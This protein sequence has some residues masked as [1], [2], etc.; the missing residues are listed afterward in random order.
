[1]TDNGRRNN[2]TPNE[3]VA[4][5]ERDQDDGGDRDRKNSAKQS[6]C[7]QPEDPIQQAEREL[8]EAQGK[9][10]DAKDQAKRDEEIAKAI[11][12]YRGEQLLLEAEAGALQAQLAEGLE[13][14]NPTEAE[15]T[16]VGSVK[17]SATDAVETLETA[18][19]TQRQSLDTLRGA[20]ATTAT[21]LAEAKAEFDALKALG[22]NVQTKHRTADGLRKEAFDAIAQG[23]R[24]LAYYL[25]RHRLQTT[26][27]DEPVPIEVDDYSSQ[28]RDQAD[29]I[30]TLST[31]HRTDEATIK[32]QAKQLTDLEKALD[33]RRKSL[34]STI[35]G[36]LATRQ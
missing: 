3:D 2:P 26:I 6:P 33:D 15:K 14:L 8:Q 9:L 16:T 36:K 12:Q 23:K 20:L 34:E 27:N 5:A 31:K 30:R 10:A 13:D 1:M 24:H 22:K 4:L 17:N 7:P 29:N 28:I 25:L 18:V 21:E 11:A 19:T 32:A 35:R